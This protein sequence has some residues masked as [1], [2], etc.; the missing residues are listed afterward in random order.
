V[1][2]QPSG[3]LDAVWAPSQHDEMNNPPSR[4]G[5]KAYVRRWDIWRKA[6]AAFV[7][8]VNDPTIPSDTL[9]P[10]AIPEKVIL[11]RA[12]ARGPR[13]IPLGLRYFILKSDN[14][15]CVLDGRSLATE[16]GVTLHV[17]HIVPW[18]KGGV[19]IAS[20]LRT[21]CSDCNLGKG[22]TTE[23]EIYPPLRGGSCG[24]LNGRSAP[25]NK[26]SQLAQFIPQ[27]R[28]VGSLPP[29]DWMNRGTTCRSL[30][31]LRCSRNGE[32][33]T[34]RGSASLEASSEQGPARSIHEG[35]YYNRQYAATTSLRAGGL[36]ARSV[37]ILF[38]YASLPRGSTRPSRVASQRF[39]H[40][41]S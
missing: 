4:V 18:I 29:H 34:V 33:Y 31:P 25:S 21:L 5:A 32:A 14:F 2:R 12:D 8:R 26:S 24:T 19:T 1:L 40:E 23:T 28:S 10:Q 7:A 15:R 39:R 16:R 20:N 13:E 36:A 35:F 38:K 30:R 3:R 27:S 41:P 22:A 37:N 17:D 9:T 6:L 11:S